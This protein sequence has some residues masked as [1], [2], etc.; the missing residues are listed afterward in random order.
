MKT[1]RAQ[2]RFVSQLEY[3]NTGIMEKWVL[4]KWNNGSLKES[5]ISRLP[6]P[7]ASPARLE[8][9]PAGKQWQA[10]MREAKTPGSKN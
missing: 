6:R 2:L 3:W 9:G 8:G 5:Y 7:S 1:I 4:E 10:E